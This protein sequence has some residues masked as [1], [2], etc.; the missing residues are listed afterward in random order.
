MSKGMK[1]ITSLF[2]AVFIILFAI[3]GTSVFAADKTLDMSAALSDISVASGDSFE[4]TL[5]FAN[6]IGI[7]GGIRAFKITLLFDSSKLT[8]SDVTWNSSVSE[9]LEHAVPQDGKLVLL[10]AD[11]QN[12]SD[13]LLSNTSFQ[14]TFTVKSGVSGNADISISENETSI[15]D[16]SYPISSVLAEL[17][18][19]TVASSATGAAKSI[20]IRELQV[21]FDDLI[22]NVQTGYI[23]NI[24]PGTLNDMFTAKIINATG[25]NVD[26]TVGGKI[27][28]GSVLTYSFGGTEY[29]YTTVIYGDIDSDSDIDIYDVIKLKNHILG[30]ETLTGANEKAGKTV[31]G[32]HVSILDLLFVKE[33]VLGGPQIA[34]NVA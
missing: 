11:V 34:Q 6:F 33:H 23:T 22:V 20:E 31:G 2:A 19:R 24:Q 13:P 4:Y 28:T 26:G 7:S 21:G 9:E 30:R 3:G 12:G 14:I 5:S 10:Y 15:I 32:S 25:V 1:R 8:F 17:R 18:A 27:A 16:C 29:R